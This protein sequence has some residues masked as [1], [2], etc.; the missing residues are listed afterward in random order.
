MDSC[1]IFS[2]CPSPKYVTYLCKSAIVVV[3]HCSNCEACMNIFVLFLVQISSFSLVQW[4]P[5][6]TLFQMKWCVCHSPL[7]MMMSRKTIRCSPSDLSQMIQLCAYARTL[8][9]L[10]CLRMQLMVCLSIRE[11]PIFLVLNLVEDCQSVQ[12][13][14]TKARLHSTIFDKCNIV[15][16]LL[17]TEKVIRKVNRL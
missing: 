12:F 13:Y 16:S 3:F 9:S 17:L 14:F 2:P 11:S 5:Q 6:W 1:Q 4:P 10:Q 7:L 8:E 15:Y